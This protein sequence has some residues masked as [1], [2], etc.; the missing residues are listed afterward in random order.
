MKMKMDYVIFSAGIIVTL[1]TVLPAFN[2]LLISSPID[3]SISVVSQNTATLAIING[4][5]EWAHFESGKLVIDFDSVAI[6]ERQT[7][8]F[9]KEGDPVFKIQNNYDQ[10]ITVNITVTSTNVPDNMTITIYV[11]NGTSDVQS[12]TINSQTETGTVGTF[13]LSASAIA[14]VWIKVETTGASA[15]TV[16]VNLS[17]DGV[18]E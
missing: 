6:G 5:D 4:N 3:S 15:T 12:Y 10:T 13:N 18:V 16:S 9:G 1:M 7:V 8:Q 17:I 14:D 11:K 2:Y